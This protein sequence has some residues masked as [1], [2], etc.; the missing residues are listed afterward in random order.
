MGHS[1]DF[2]SNSEFKRRQ[3]QREKE[4]KKAAKAADAP[5]TATKPKNAEEGE[6]ELNPNVSSSR[7]DDMGGIDQS[8]TLNIAIL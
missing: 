5:V 7:N 1:I 4:A 8:L 2:F 3:K 6:D